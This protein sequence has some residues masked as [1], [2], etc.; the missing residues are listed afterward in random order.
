MSS[1]VEQWIELAGIALNI[2]I[3]GLEDDKDGEEEGEY[4]E[5]EG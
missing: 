5:E 2:V 4:V 3:T 1:K